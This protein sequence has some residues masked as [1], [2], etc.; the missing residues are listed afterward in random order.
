TGIS[1]AVYLEGIVEAWR[2][3]R[4]LGDEARATRYAESV[5]RAARF[6]AQLRFR[7]EECYYVQSPRDVV[8]G[9]RNTP[10]DPTLRIDHSQH[11]LAGLVGA[12]E[13][14]AATSQPAPG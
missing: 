5:R 12:A 2:T 6:V 3:A 10:A 9:M 11:A 7:P 8:G 14:L 4:T 13:V 1:S